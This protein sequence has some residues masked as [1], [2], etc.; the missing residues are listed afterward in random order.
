MLTKWLGNPD[1]IFD[2]SLYVQKGYEKA[3]GDFSEQDRELFSRLRVSLPELNGW[4]DLPLCIALG[5]FFQEVYLV[6]WMKMS[7]SEL[8]RENLIEFLA[9]LHYQQTSGDWPWGGDI[10]KLS[11]IVRSQ[12][13]H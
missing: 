1:F 8:R 4:G 12:T 13:H 10:D 6:S 9:F 5:D 3:D 7:D 2:A 11:E